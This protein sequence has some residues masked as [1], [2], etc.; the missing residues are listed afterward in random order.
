MRF[1][2][3]PLLILSTCLALHAGAADAFGVWRI[4]FNRST[5]AH[6]QAVVVRFEP[7]SKGEVFTLEMVDRD[8]RSTTTS[9]ILY[10]D[11]KERE[12]AGFGCSGTQSSRQLDTQ[13]VE[14]LHACR[15]GEWTRILRRLSGDAKELVLE[16]TEQQTE[17]RRFDRRLVMEKQ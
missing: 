1:V 4:N 14:I 11:G 10:L 7:H 15:S 8:G 5:N 2:P 6:N 9:T 16:I 12:F 3:P 13:T 17:F